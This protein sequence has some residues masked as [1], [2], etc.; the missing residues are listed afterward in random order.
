VYGLVAYDVFLVRYPNDGAL[1]MDG[2][3]YGLKPIW[4]LPLKTF[5][6]NHNQTKGSFVWL[7]AIEKEFDSVSK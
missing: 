2:W 3:M 6:I 1:W 5:D 7:W 4:V